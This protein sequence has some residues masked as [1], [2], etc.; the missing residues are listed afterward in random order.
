MPKSRVEIW[1]ETQEEKGRRP[2]MSLQGEMDFV[3]N[4]LLTK[5]ASLRLT[6]RRLR[7]QCEEVKELV[8][9]IREIQRRA[10]ISHEEWFEEYKKSWKDILLFYYSA[11]A[12]KRE[13]LRETEARRRNE[14]KTTD[15]SV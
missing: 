13:E 9:E 12:E 2:S 7:Q 14:Q 15:E 6:L 3:E 1:R 10:G 11:K 5:S 8:K 4:I